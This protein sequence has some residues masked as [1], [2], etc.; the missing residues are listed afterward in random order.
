[1]ILGI[2]SNIAFSL[3]AITY[4]PVFLQKIRQADDPKRLWQERWGNFASDR[5]AVKSSERKRVWIHAVSVGEVRSLVPLLEQLSKKGFE[6]LLSTVTPTGQQE[7]EKLVGDRAFYFPFDLSAAVRKTLNVIQPDMVL[8]T[9]TELWPNFILQTARQGIPLGVINGRLSVRSFGRYQ[10]IKGAMKQLL[11]KISFFAM[12][13][14]QDAGRLLNL[15]ADSSKVF[16]L[17]NMKFDAKPLLPGR[18]PKEIKDSFNIPAHHKVWVAGST[19]LGEERHLLA[20]FT[21]LKS[22]Y[23]SLTL[24]VAPRHVERAESIL[25]LATEFNFKPLRLGEEKSSETTKGADVLVVDTIGQLNNLYSFA[26]I[27][28]MGGSL[29]EH[30]GQNPIE[31]ALFK[32]SVLTGPHV[33]NFKYVYEQLEKAEAVE[34]VISEDELFLKAKELMASEPLRDAM[35]QRA[36]EQVMNLGGATTKTLHLISRFLDNST[37]VSVDSPI[38]SLAVSDSVS[39]VEDSCPAS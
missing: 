21:R 35:G 13:T 5:F 26:D 4:I 30:G 32:K 17:G 33:F 2:I 3:F 34:M 11:D 8:L 23:S 16:V 18:S 31:P 7:A 37:H 22:I 24:I 38:D 36:Y 12:Q 1:M 15:G 28:F 10:L 14:D 19:H 29:V 39:K 27:V 6:V 20:V 9:E 25:R